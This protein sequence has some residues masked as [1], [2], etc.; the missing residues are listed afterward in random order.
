[1]A[2]SKILKELANNE[3]ALDVAFK[4]LL[5]ICNDLNYTE[6]FAW[7]EKELNG[8]GVEE[9]VP[10]NRNL[11]VGKLMY[12]GLKGTMASCLKLSNQPLPIQWIPEKYMDLLCNNYERCTIANIVERA[13]SGSNFSRDLTSLAGGISVGIAFTSI[14]QRFDSSTYMEIV[15]K[16]SNILFKIF[17]K[18]DKEYGNLDDLDIDTA[19]KSVEE[20]ANFEK[21]LIIEVG[22]LKMIN[23]GSDNTIKN[24]NIGAGEV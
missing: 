9:P 8:Y 23:I 7:A 17:M 3:I 24:S 13:K 18:L 20:V 14:S 4:R 16:V 6:I 15:N 5:L 21:M 22:E 1:M 12:S 11:G 2:K 10:E 19:G